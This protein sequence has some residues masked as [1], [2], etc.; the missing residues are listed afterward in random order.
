MQPTSGSLADFIRDCG[1]RSLVIGTST[2]PNPKLTVL[3]VAPH[4]KRPILAV[5]APTTA[6]AALTLKAETR[7]LRELRAVPAR[8]ILETV[9]SV[10]DTF[11]YHGRPALVMTAL[12]GKPMS[13]IY[14]RRGH[15]ADP[16]LVAEDFAAVGSW[17]AELQLATAAESGALDID[18]G[19]ELPHADLETL[20]PIRARLRRE[21]VPMTAVH[22]D[23][24]LGNVLLEHGRV[25]GV[26]DWEFGA[27]RGQPVRDLVRFALTYALYLDRRTRSGRR[28]KGH[29]ALRAGRFGAPLEYSLDGEGWFPELFRRFICDGLERLGASPAAWRDACLAGIAEVA[30]QAD[31]RQF[32]RRHLEV[33]RRL[34]RR[35]NSKETQ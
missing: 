14:L 10:V 12:P 35:H 30:A 13:S 2:N 20:A 16:H 5:K 19:G 21:R 7:L 34:T 18:P 33:F 27:M 15:T 28:V 3:L 24:W 29:H 23:L 11:D 26:V 25:S 9:P 4:G 22:G 1:L 8:C 31:D 6:A 17:L 32:A